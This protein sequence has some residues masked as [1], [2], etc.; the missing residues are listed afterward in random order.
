MLLNA[1][2]LHG[3][4]VAASDAPAGEVKDTYF[5]DERWVIRY[6]IVDTRA[7]VRGREVLI[8]PVAVSHVDFE[9][10]RVD[11]SVSQKH[12]DESPSIDAAMPVSRMMESQLNRYYGYPDYWS[13]GAT[14]PVWGWGDMPVLPPNLAVPAVP[15]DSG[16]PGT[17]LRSMREVIGYHIKAR[18]DT[19]GHVEDMLIDPESWAIRY[20]V[21]DTRNWWPGPPV[22]LG[23]E[24]ASDIDWST[25]T[26]AVDMDAERIKACPPY[27]PSQPISR[28]YEADLHK[29]YGRSVYWRQ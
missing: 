3:F 18:D 11:L 15:T 1:K 8:S 25:R 26:L 6:L 27:D 16:D 17:H 28:Q 7:W 21:I 4:N 20:L 9:R 14:S 22:L 2:T 23:I 10:Q 19:F 12:V 13:F 24:W 5:D 29:Y